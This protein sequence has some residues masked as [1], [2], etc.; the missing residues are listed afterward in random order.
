M[1]THSPL[2]S[3]RTARVARSARRTGTCVAQQ[4]RYPKDPRRRGHSSQNGPRQNRKEEK[5]RNGGIKR[6]KRNGKRQVKKE[7]KGRR[8]KESRE[9]GARRVRKKQEAGKIRSDPAV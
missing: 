4:L 3:E 9:N 8:R 6:I 7:E 2:T 1:T 5:R